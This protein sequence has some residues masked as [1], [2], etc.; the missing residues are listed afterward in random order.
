MSQCVGHVKNGN[1]CKRNAVP[2][3]NFCW[4][5]SEESDIK[6][7]SAHPEVQ[8]IIIPK[9]IPKPINTNYRENTLIG[10]AFPADILRNITQLVDIPPETGKIF[11]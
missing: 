4:Q 9:N 10:K 8:K 7:L 5:H 6:N 11:N 1:R 2:G 3:S